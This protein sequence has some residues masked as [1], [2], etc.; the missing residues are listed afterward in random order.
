[1]DDEDVN[2]LP[3]VTP[4]AR[5]RDEQGVSL[6]LLALVPASR[7]R[8]PDRGAATERFSKID[9]RVWECLT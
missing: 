7:V 9:D 8:V 5:G 2:A 1:M 6:P 3:P 4:S